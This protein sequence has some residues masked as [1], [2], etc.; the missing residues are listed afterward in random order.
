MLALSLFKR[1]E[2]REIASKTEH[3]TE[4]TVQVQGSDLIFLCTVNAMLF[5]E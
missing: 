2:E 3:E 1:Q 5:D 4:A